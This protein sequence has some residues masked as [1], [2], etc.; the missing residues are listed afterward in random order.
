MMTHQQPSNFL[1]HFLYLRLNL[2]GTRVGFEELLV[3]RAPQHLPDLNPSDESP[4]SR[5]DDTPLPVNWAL[6]EDTRIENRDVDS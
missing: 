4:D 6:V 3:Q 5:K 2:Q 1:F